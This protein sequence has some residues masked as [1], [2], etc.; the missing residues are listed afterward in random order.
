L[1]L[2]NNTLRR[3]SSAGKLGIMAISREHARVFR[4]GSKTYFN[5]S[6]FFPPRI[7]ERVFALYA[8]VRVA[9]NYVD[10][11]PQQ[12]EEFR[13]FRRRCEAARAG[14]PAGDAI[15]DPFLKLSAECDFDSAWTEAFLDSMEADISKQNYDTLEETLGYVYGSAEVIGLFMT[16]IMELPDEALP[17]AAMLGRA[18]QYINFIRDIAEDTSLGRRYLSLNGTSP[19][20]V[21]ADYARKNPAEFS[22]FIGGHLALYRLWQ[23]EAVAGY[24]FIPRRYRVPI[25]TAADMY[26]WTAERIA[27]RP[28]VVFDQKVKPSRGRIYAKIAHNTVFC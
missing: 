3:L 7:R 8:F 26:W 11:V 1:E 6:I 22:A 24:R 28:L 9:D 4:S 21:T 18:M 14:K 5:S 12:A 19:R 10:A 16:R 15:I 20:I 25:K 13:N 27:A 2:L 17:A 23:K